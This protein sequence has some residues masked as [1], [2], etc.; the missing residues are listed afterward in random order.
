MAEADTDTILE[1]VAQL[2][3][4]VERARF[5]GDEPALVV[6]PDDPPAVIVAK[7]LAAERLNAPLRLGDQIVPLQE[8]VA[9]ALFYRGVTALR[10]WRFPVAQAAFEEAGAKTT[11]PVLQQRLALYRAVAALLRRMVLADPDQ[12]VKALPEERALG[13]VDTLDALA[14]AERAHYRAELERLITLRRALPADPY[15]QTVHGLLRARLALTAGDDA[16]GLGWLLRAAVL[17]ADRLEP[18]PYL[19]DLLA[20]ARRR[21]RRFLGDPDPDPAAGQ[22]VPASAEPLAEPPLDPPDAAPDEGDDVRAGEL[23]AALASH[24]DVLLGRDVQGDTAQFG[25]VLYHE[26]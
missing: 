15:L 8:D 1:L 5:A 3:R 24:L 12:P 13:L 16:L 21:L 4:D 22:A 17:H 19:A 9:E 14:E 26:E 18:S 6:A 20:R 23:L 7:T 10:Y 25:V 11:A 2:R